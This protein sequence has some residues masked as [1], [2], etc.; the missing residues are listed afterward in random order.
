MWRAAVLVAA[1]CLVASAC[2]SRTD[3][4]SAGAQQTTTTTGQGLE[5]GVASPTT[6]ASATSTTPPT[7]K[8]P[9]R[10]TT[11]ATGSKAAGTRVA[12][13]A[14]ASP[15][16]TSRTTEPGPTT[17]STVPGPGS[18]GLEFDA[19]SGLAFGPRSLWVSNSRGNSVT[20]IDPSNGAWVATLR[21]PG[22]GFDDP[23]AITDVGANLFVANGGGFV[24]ELD[25]TSGA[26]VRTIRG[27]QYHFA[28]PVALASEGNTLLV[29]N[30][31]QPSS[32]TEIDLSTGQLVRVASGPSFDFGDPV[33]LAVWGDDAFVADEGSNAV[34]EVDI[35]NGARVGEPITGPFSAP[36]GIAAEDGNV[37][38]TN[39]AGNSA[40]QID[41][42]TGTVKTT[43]NDGS[44]GFN[45]P[46][47]AIAWPGYVFIATPNGTSPMV[48]MVNATTGA[49][50]WDGTGSAAF[51]CNSNG[52]YYFSNISAFAVA[53]DD[54]W[55]ASRTGANYPSSKADY[56]S[57]TE[58][59]TTT[60]N[61]LMRTVA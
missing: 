5:P 6:G 32:L 38:V 52:P 10:S 60:F 37:W 50:G 36:D 31:G 4:R 43:V 35:S 28:D 59:S 23:T 20:E 14:T 21:G 61:G 9:P 57:L 19:P 48:T 56:G 16:T 7:S 22:Y 8:A 3:H 42:A 12:T 39:S 41:A 11:T 58:L 49:G 26:A 46:S 13:G 47:V 30:A 24:T 53:G 55:V 1:T 54:L 2:S 45:T 40:T 15:R 33:A 44:Y 51:V 27:A 34:T 18:Q 17:T 25:A 29:L